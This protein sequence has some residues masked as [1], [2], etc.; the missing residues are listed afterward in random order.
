MMMV[1]EDRNMQHESILINETD[2][3]AILILSVNY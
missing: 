2:L 1:G 3:M